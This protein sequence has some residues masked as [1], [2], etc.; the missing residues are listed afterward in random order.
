MKKN[1]L[2][3]AIKSV[4]ALFGVMLFQFEPLAQVSDNYIV[5][6]G[7]VTNNEFGNAL[8]NHKVYFLKDSTV[9][10]DSGPLLTEVVTDDEGFYYDTILTRTSKGSL[11]IYT[12]DFYGLTIDTV[13]YYRFVTYTHS[14]I[15]ISNFDIFMPVQAD[16]LQSRFRFEQ[17]KDKNRREAPIRN[18]T[19]LNDIKLINLYTI[20]THED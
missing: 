5:V 13:K 2:S 9:T 4:L 10:I 16:L 1:I 20:D 6:S 3:I 18:D 17:K 12:E 15:I 19:L 14:N 11:L 7:Q 8:K